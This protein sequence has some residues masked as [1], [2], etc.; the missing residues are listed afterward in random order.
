[1]NNRTRRNCTKT[2][3]CQSHFIYT[4]IKWELTWRN[5]STMQIAACL[6]YSAS[7]FYFKIGEYCRLHSV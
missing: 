2:G 5:N 6:H 4:S 7:N 3:C 1:M